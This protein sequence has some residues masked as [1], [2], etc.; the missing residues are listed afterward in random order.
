MKIPQCIKMGGHEISIIKR[1][2]DK[3]PVDGAIGVFGYFDSEK[4]EIH[5]NLTAP[6]SV[7]WETFVH[8]IIEATCFFTETPLPHSTIQSFGLLISQAIQDA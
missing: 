4:L 1:N 7:Q 3:E 5:I 8:E 2:L 6:E